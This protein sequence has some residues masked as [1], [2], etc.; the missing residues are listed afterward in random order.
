MRSSPW[1]ATSSA[2]TALI[3]RS[4]A[5]PHPGTIPSATA[6]LVAW[7]AS[8]KA[9]SR[10]FIS[11]SD[12]APTRTTAT[13]PDVLELHADLGAHHAATGQHGDVLHHLLAAV[14]VTRRLHRHAPQ[15]AVQSVH[16]QGG[17]RL[18]LDVLGDD[19]HRV[20]RP[21]HLLQQ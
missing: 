16:D 7:I 18:A 1:T 8:S 12:G 2:S 3:I 21:R 10:L 13:P 9:S 20:S 4:R 11:A 6:A 14:A 19:H 17:Q 5:S 15:R